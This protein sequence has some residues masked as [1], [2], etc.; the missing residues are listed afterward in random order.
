MSTAHATIELLKAL[1]RGERRV[2]GAQVALKGEWQHRHGVLGVQVLLS[3]E[4]WSDLVEMELADDETK[5]L[6]ASA[7]A[8]ALRN[9][10]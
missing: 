2:V 8:I 1:L 6:L 4:G 5:A 10:D 9:Q 3:P 7:E